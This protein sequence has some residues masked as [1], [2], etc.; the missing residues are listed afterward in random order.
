M[1]TAD[2]QTEISHGSN[3]RGMETTATYDRDTETFVL[4]SGTLGSTKW[5]PAA[6]GRTAT[7]AIIHARLVLHTGEMVGIKPFFVQLRDL[8]TT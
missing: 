2:G 1:T 7:H 6:L 8:T 5:W 3:V 4:H